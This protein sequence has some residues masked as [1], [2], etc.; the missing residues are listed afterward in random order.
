VR[1]GFAPYAETYGAGTP[2]CMCEGQGFDVDGFGRVWYTNLFRFR[3]EVADAANNTVAT[4]GA[5]GSQN[6]LGAGK[7]LAAAEGSPA[8]PAA[9][10]PAPKTGPRHPDI[11][12][13]WPC[14]VA[15]S[16]DCAYVNDTVGMRVVRVK[17]GAAAEE[18]CPVGP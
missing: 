16:D 6:S 9:G 3:V 2:V 5:Y 11:P 7:G 13:A 12:L 18:S 14:Y 15:V 10:A 17:L 1:F 4:F 8:V